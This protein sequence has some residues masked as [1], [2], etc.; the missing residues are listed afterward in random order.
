MR[1]TQ[2]QH[3]LLLSA[4]LLVLRLKYPIIFCKHAFYISIYISS[5]VAALT[6]HNLP[7]LLKT[8]P[9]TC[10]SFFLSFQSQAMA[11]RKTSTKEQLPS[12]DTMLTS[13]INM[14]N[15]RLPPLTNAQT[16]HRRSYA[17]RTKTNSSRP[18]F[19][20]LTDMPGGPTQHKSSGRASASFQP[21]PI[22]QSGPSRAS[23]SRLRYQGTTGGQR[24]S[25]ERRTCRECRKE[26]KR[27]SDA[28]KHMSTVHATA[29]AFMCRVCK[30][31]FARKD[32]LQVRLELPLSVAQVTMVPLSI[33]R[34][35]LRIL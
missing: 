24:S 5:Q 4:L 3:T 28:N 35:I 13:S 14:N 9:F 16:G 20:S 23:N 2:G 25:V 34:S 6:S 19:S 1:D 11:S 26:F 15:L 29:K 12:V 27:P 7:H 22:H 17:P 31:K 30:Q 8:H 21:L 33:L 32:Y 10:T 18:G